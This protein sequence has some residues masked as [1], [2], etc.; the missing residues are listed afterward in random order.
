MLATTA[1]AAHPVFR[2]RQDRQSNQDAVPEPG[3]GSGRPSP[4]R[5][6]LQRSIWGGA[7]SGNLRSIPYHILVPVPLL[8][9]GTVT[10]PGTHELFRAYR[11][12]RPSPPAGIPAAPAACR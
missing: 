4:A 8:Y 2:G 7:C 3:G 10:S 5:S 11:L 1:G 9:T 12:P 6:N